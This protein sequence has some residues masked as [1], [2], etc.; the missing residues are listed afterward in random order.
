[1]ISLMASTLPARPEHKLQ[2]GFANLG[3]AVHLNP[4]LFP[5]SPP[6]CRPIR[7]NVDFLRRGLWETT[8][9][10]LDGFAVLGCLPKVQEA[11]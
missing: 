8:S 1:M 3:L 4:H 2:G 9:F 6:S 7:G 5:A 11:D 10:R